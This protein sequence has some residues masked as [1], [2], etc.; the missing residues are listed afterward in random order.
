LVDLIFSNL[1][2]SHNLSDASDNNVSSNNVS[3]ASGNLLRLLFTS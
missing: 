3:D 1:I 2:D